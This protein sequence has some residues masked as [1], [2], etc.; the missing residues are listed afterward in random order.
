MHRLLRYAG[1]V[2]RLSGGAMAE[3]TKRTT[4][5]STD[6]GS[7]FTSEQNIERFV[8]TLARMRGAALK[9]GQMLSIQGMAPP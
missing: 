9:I 1:L 7:V 5:L 3:V 8:D 6:K 2:A 4:G